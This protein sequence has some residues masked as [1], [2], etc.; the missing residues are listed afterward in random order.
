MSAA[1]KKRPSLL[2]AVSAGEA[3]TVARHKHHSSLYHGLQILQLLLR[4]GRSLGV[5]EIARESKLAVS[6]THDL[7]ATLGEL[8]F[9]DQNPETKRYSVSPEIF[10]FFRL[11]SNEFGHNSQVNR[12][13]RDYC[14]KHNATLYLSML[15]RTRSYVVCA[16][17]PL[18]DTVAIGANSP[19]Y[20]SSCGKAIVAQLPTNQWQDYVPDE[21]DSKLTPYTKQSQQGFLREL[22]CAREAGVGWNIQETTVGLCSVAAPIFARGKATDRAVAIVLPHGE[23]VARDRERLAMEIKGVAAVIAST[24]FG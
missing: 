7:L 10:A 22:A 20:A 5:S 2:P 11:F 6:T 9:V 1:A 16:S 15:C 17:G 21:G 13:L 18:G 24:L 23:W 12:I 8:N 14:A 3:V 19:A 4:F